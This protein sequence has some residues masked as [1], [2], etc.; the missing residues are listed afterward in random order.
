MS[1]KPKLK[2]V[3]VTTRKPTRASVA[4]HQALADMKGVGQGIHP[5]FANKYL[6]KT[7]LK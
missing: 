3:V 6:R 7:R 2:N 4:A 5:P 1:D